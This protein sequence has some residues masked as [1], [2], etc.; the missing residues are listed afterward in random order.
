MED[1]IR[2]D[3]QIALVTGGGRG[4]GRAIARRLAAAGAVVVVAARS[5]DQVSETAAEI[6][7]AGG[8]ASSVQVDVGDRASVERTVAQVLR[9]VGPIDLLVNNAG[10]GGPLGKFMDVDPDDWWRNLEVNVRGPV[11][12]CHAV[13]PGMLAR[14]R[15]RIVNLISDA[16]FHPLPFLSAYS[17]SKTALQRLGENLAAEYG[18][19][20]IVVFGLDP[21]LVRTSLVDGALRSDVPVLAQA[22]QGLLDQGVNIPPERAAEVVALLATGQAD[23][24]SGRYFDANEDPLGVLERADEIRDTDLYVLRVRR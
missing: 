19:Q 14:G 22:F 2:L 23:A 8:Q 9:E 13:L 10:I 6:E 21:G 17:V 24:F 18:E 5:R 3:G 20:G 1:S 7:A 4:I 15:G 16:G 12:L 11:Y